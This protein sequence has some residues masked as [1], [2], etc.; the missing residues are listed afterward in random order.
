MT[1]LWI[2]VV[3]VSW[4][5]VRKMEK[6]GWGEGICSSERTRWVIFWVF[7]GRVKLIVWGN[8]PY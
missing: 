8:L 2:V 3:V 6:A 1:K 4:E 5:V 7:A